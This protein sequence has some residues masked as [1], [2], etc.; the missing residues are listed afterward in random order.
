MIAA[1]LIA[2][3]LAAEAMAQAPAYPKMAPVEAYLMD[4][5]AEIALARSAAPEAVSKDATVLVLT[6]R[7]Y[8]TAAKG[9]NGFV[10]MVERGW[11]GAL[12]APEMFNPKIKGAD[13]LNPAAARSVLPLAELRTELF[14]AGRSPAEVMARLK[15]LYAAGK[16]PALAPG[17]MSYMMGKGSYL[18]D[19]GSHNGPHLMFFMPFAEPAP[20]GSDL[21]GSPVA[22]GGYWS[23]FA[24]PPMDAGGLPPM[25]VFI[26]P[27]AKWSDGAPTAAHVH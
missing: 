6:R 27:M 24:T 7:G 17:A 14:L 21:P 3:L 9:T 15:A 8:E 10:C 13:C 23:G 20:W 12:D 26:I 19:A 25:R 1:F 16:A 11:V 4:R 18:T 5:D 22:S 2:G